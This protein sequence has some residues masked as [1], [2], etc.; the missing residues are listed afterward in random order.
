LAFV[1]AEIS[2]AARMAAAH[3]AHAR[4][5]IVLNLH[6]VP[7][8]HFMRAFQ[9][10]ACLPDLMFPDSAKASPTQIEVV[11]L[12]HGVARRCVGRSDRTV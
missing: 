3:F 1:N 11:V 7:N 4:G 12:H 9:C 5:R 2:A 8:H 6:E 10:A